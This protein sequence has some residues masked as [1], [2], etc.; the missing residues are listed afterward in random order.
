METLQCIKGRRSIRHF[1]EQ[2]VSEEIL[3]ELLE[4]VRWAPSWANSQCWEII[5]VKEKENKAKLAELLA[6]GNPA[7]KATIQ[8][9]LVLVFC[10]KKGLAGFKKGVAMTN[11]GDWYMFDLG[12]ACQ[13]LCLAAHDLGL[14]T[15]QVGN[16]DHEG[17]DK[18][19]NISDGAESVLIIPLGYPAKEGVAPPRRGIDGF[20]YRERYS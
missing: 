20:V 12:L 1:T 13:N 17:V 2:E 15:V 6:E 7:T 11:K 5:I 8:A 16:F 10:G 9:P 14:G 18:L 19:L 3:Q 4:A